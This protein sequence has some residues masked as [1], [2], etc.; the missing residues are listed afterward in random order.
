MRPSLVLHRKPWHRAGRGRLGRITMESADVQRDQ[1]VAAAETVALVLD[2]ESPLPGSA[3]DVEELARR[4]RGHISQLAV[5]VPPGAPALRGA[6]QLAAAGVPDGYMPSRV[7][8]VKLAEATQAFVA[9]VQAHGVAPAKPTRRWRW[10]K[11]QINVLR[12][13]VFAVAFA[14]LVL[15]ASVPRA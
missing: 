6:Q 9:T 11:P 3:G 10:W 7:H 1:A 14:C 15:A 12:G 2:E 13:S 5:V 8:L 4:L